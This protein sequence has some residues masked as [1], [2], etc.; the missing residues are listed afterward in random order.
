MVL[1]HRHVAAVV[2]VAIYIDF[3]WPDPQFHFNGVTH[4]D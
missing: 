1:I 2:H 4:A 3:A